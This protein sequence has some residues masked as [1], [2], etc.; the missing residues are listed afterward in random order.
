M[1]GETVCRETVSILRALVF[2]ADG[3]CVEIGLWSIL[4][5]AAAF[6]LGVVGLQFGAR[7]LL[8]MIFERRARARIRPGAHAVAQP[9]PEPPAQPPEPA[10]APRG[11]VGKTAYDGGP[12]KT[13]RR[14]R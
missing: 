12:I 1:F 3:A 13:R 11:R 8:Y 9:V 10:P 4:P 5:V 2:G 7:M 6:V 14:W